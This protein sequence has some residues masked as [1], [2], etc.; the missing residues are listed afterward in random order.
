MPKKKIE[1]KKL[2]KLQLKQPLRP[3][4]DPPLAEKPQNRPV[5]RE[6]DATG[7]VLGRLA[8]HVAVILRGKDKPE[9]RPNLICGDKV[10]V[11]NAS[12]IIITGRKLEQKKYYHHTGY[13]GHLKEKSMKELMAKNPAE[14]VRR[15]VYG[16]LPDNKLR[17]ILMK[18]LEILN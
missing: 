5:I 12:K 14:V 16:M 10:K 4:A 11:T 17:P 6:I 7:Q 18:N 9:F 15:A 2:E 8:T 13:L 3:K 1:P